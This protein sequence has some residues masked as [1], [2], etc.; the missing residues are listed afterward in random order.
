MKRNKM[1]WNGAIVEGDS[2]GLKADIAARRQL[3]RQV[4]MSI[5][6]LVT[7]FRPLAA[8]ALDR[9]PIGSAWIGEGPPSE[10]LQLGDGGEI[11]G[12]VRPLAQPSLH[13]LGLQAEV[14]GR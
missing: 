12:Q 2:R 14:E 10:R 7:L 13:A 4:Q 11:G 1:E 3:A 5:I 6:L 9:A 8:T